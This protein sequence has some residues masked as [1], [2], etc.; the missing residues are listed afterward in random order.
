[1]KLKL[2]VLGLQ[3]DVEEHV[4]AWERA[5]DV[6]GIQADVVIVKQPNQLEG[7]TAISIP[8]GESTV[9]G[10]LAENSKLLEKLKEGVLNGLPALGTCAGMI[11]LSKKSRDSVVGE[12]KQPLLGVLDVDV[13]RNHFGRQPDSFERDLS[14]PVLGE[15]PYRGVFIRA[16]IIKQVGQG[17][18]VLAKIE[19]GIVAVRQA[20]IVATSFHP[21]LSD[22]PRLHV[23][24]LKQV[25]NV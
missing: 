1:M 13:E 8:G 22:D 14:I 2:G 11:L 23:Y 24:F 5:A 17:V 15:K 12:K 21:E 25:A 3:G 16:P 18:E 6:L 9:I 10:S 20:N 19:E 7:L 4:E